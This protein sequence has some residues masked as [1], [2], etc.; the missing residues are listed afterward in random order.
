MQFQAVVSLDDLSLVGMDAGLTL[1]EDGSVA[2]AVDPKGYATIPPGYDELHRRGLATVSYR[3]SS[4]T[5]ALTN[6][7][8]IAFGRAGWSVDDL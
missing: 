6:A 2:L 4:Q 1:Y 8:R 5:Y 7:A 3:G